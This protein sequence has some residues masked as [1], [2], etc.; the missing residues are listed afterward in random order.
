[1][2]PDAPPI[3]G[4]MLRLVSLID[5]FKGSWRLI[6]GMHPE[7]LD[8]LRRVATIESVGSSTRIE[9]AKLSDAE[10]EILLGRVGKQDFSS[11]DEQEVAGYARVME[12][13]FAHHGEMRFGENLVF[14]LHRDLLYHSTKDERHRGAYKTLA[15][16][17]SAFDHEGR[18]VGVIFRTA[19]PFETPG[20]MQELIA[21][22]E[23]VFGILHPLVRI[24][25]FVVEFL[26]IHPF[27]DGNGRLSRVL[28]TLLMLQ[29]GYGYVP[30][31]SLESIIE[32]NKEGY[33]LALRRTQGTMGNANPDWEPW[34]HFFLTALSKQALRLQE[35]LSETAASVQPRLGVSPGAVKILNALEAKGHITVAEAA[36]VVGISRNTAKN[37]LRELVDRGHATLQGKGRGAHYL[38]VAGPLTIG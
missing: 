24:G 14:Q 27:Q 29:A 21:W 5:E 32:Q 4:E 31:G 22:N 3:S 25:L 15:N 9:G 16:H 1:M 38:P 2:L 7:R 12:S 23:R 35:R 11:R 6:Q 26:A 13:V 20:R 10:V 8:S 33:Y 36:Q 37:K 34:I 28:T 18:E 19:S 17:V 30:Y